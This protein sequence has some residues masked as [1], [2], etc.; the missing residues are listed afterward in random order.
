MTKKTEE[1]IK[2]INRIIAE[3]AKTD[4]ENVTFK[5]TECGKK[6]IAKCMA[7]LY[8]CPKCGKVQ[9]DEEPPENF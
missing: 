8:V 9:H 3:K 4:P 1:S 5:C 7:D 6:Y 2:N